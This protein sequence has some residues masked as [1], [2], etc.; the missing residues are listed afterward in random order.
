MKKLSFLIAF[1]PFSLPTYGF[2]GSWV[3]KTASIQSITSDSC[4]GSRFCKG[5][6]GHTKSHL[7]CSSWI[8]MTF[9]SQANFI[10]RGIFPSNNAALTLATKSHHV[11]H[12]QVWV[13]LFRP[14]IQWGYRRLVEL[15]V[16]DSLSA[17]PGLGRFQIR[18]S[19]LNTL[20][21]CPSP[22]PAV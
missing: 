7:G 17:I 19:F 20:A 21:W 9:F 16:S 6:Q 1:Q 18:S 15:K 5:R 12:C 2:L 8:S 13:P 22:P 10:L 14:L 4:L 11:A 3:F